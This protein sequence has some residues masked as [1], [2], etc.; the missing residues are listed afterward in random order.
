[1][2]RRVAAGVSGAL[3]VLLVGYGAVVLFVS[4]FGIVLMAAGGAL[5]VARWMAGNRS[6]GP[7][8]LPHG[9]ALRGRGAALY[10]GLP[11]LAGLILTVAGLVLQADRSTGTGAVLAIVGLALL[12]AGVLRGLRIA[13]RGDRAP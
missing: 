4:A 10:A 11:L 9:R 8:L 13:W 6:A 3:G 2:I 1:M 12:G 5:V 7:G